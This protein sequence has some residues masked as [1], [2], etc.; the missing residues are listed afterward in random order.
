MIRS[1]VFVLL[2]GAG[3]LAVRGK[4]R[5]DDAGSTERRLHIVAHVGPASI[6]V[7]DLE[8]RIAAMPPFQRATFG[9]TR[10]A[11][12]HRFLDEVVV[13]DG[14]LAVA[15]GALK[16]GEKPPAAY[17]IER[18]R[19]GATIRAI[20]ARIGPAAAIP[21]SDVEQY[22]EENRGR[23]DTPER[24]QIWR[25]LCKTRD[26]AQA[27]LDA[28]RRDPTP[29]MFGAQA[30]EHSLDKA[31]YLRAGNLGFVDADGSSK[32]PGLRVDPA[33]VHAAQ[34]V[35]EGALVPAP[36]SEGEYFS[37]VWRRGTIPATKRSVDDV[38]SQIRDAIWKARVKEETDKLVAKLRA[39][40][41]QLLDASILGTTDIPADLDLVGGPRPHPGD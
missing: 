16:L 23:Y 13:R 21:M 36:V 1:A 5:A 17:R 35:R 15:A 33:I 29:A 4:S 39:E 7:G 9:G 3:M 20:R 34:S 10:D 19:S 18:A 30:R 41:V 2:T 11:V 22:Y 37:V 38:A 12:R 6:N 14:L 40:R 28:T 26:E 24:Y 8:D 25:I 32:E 27:V 31:T